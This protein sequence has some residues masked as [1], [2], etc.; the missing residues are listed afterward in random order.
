MDFQ[1]TDTFLTEDVFANR[2][3]NSQIVTTGG[4]YYKKLLIDPAPAIILWTQDN[5][6]EA[7]QILN[8]Q[9]NLIRS[10]PV[11]SS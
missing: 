3:E 8:D 10:V 6:I 7:Y 2:A 5:Q 9:Y 11:T 1:T 4:Y